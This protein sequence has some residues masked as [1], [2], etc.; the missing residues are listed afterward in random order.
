MQVSSGIIIVELVS[1]IVFPLGS[2][3]GS[4]YGPPIGLQFILCISPRSKV[5]YPD[6]VGSPSRDIIVVNPVEHVLN[7]VPLP[8]VT[9][10]TLYQRLG[11]NRLWC[12]T[13]GNSKVDFWITFI[14]VENTQL[15]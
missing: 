6:F 1:D 9:R 4:N 14:K 15:K 2:L 13:K 7:F 3:L 8:S 5:I 12:D 10:H 11:H